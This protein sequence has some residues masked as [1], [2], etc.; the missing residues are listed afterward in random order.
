VVERGAVNTVQELLEGRAP[1]VVIQ[2]GSGNVGSGGRITVRGGTS[3]TLDN[4]PLLYVDGVR[5]SNAQATGPLSQ[6]FSPGPISRMNDFDPD[7]IERVEIIKGP[8]AATLYGTEASTGVINVITKKGAVGPAR[9]TVATRIGSAWLRDPEGRFPI[10]YGRD[11]AKNVVGL[12][13]VERENARGTPIF[14]R[15]TSQAYHLG[16]SAGTERL[17]YHLG[18]GYEASDGIERANQLRKHSARLNVTLVPTDRLSVEA[19]LGHVGGPTRLSPEG[20]HGSRMRAT[21]NSNPSNLPGMAPPGDTTRRG[22]GV[23]LPEEYDL[24]VT[25]GGAFEQDVDRLTASFHVEHRTLRWLSQRLRAGYDRTDATNTAFYPRVDALVAKSP[26]ANRRFG[27]KEITVTDGQYRTLD[28]AATASR[29]LRGGLR[30]STSIGGQYYRSGTNRM[31]SSGAD[32]PAEGLTAISSTTG[33]RVTEGDFAEDVT[34]GIYAEE[35]VAW[36]DRL[37]VTA[38]LR[39]DDNS[40]FGEN[41]DRIVYPKAAVS[42]VA[43]DERFVRV[44]WL[45]TLRLRAAY[46]EAGKQPSA[47][48]ALRTYQAVTGPGDGMAVTPLGIGNPNLR[49]ERGKE[50]EIGFDAAALGDRLSLDL[51]YYRKRTLDAIVPRELPPSGGVPGVQLLNVG[52]IRNSGIELL[53]R[54]TPWRSEGWTWDLSLNLATNENVVVSLG[55]PTLQ[56]LPAGEYRAHRTGHPAGSWFERRVLS[57]AMDSTGAVSNVMCDDGRGGATSCAGPDGSYGTADDAPSVY[58]GRTIPSVTDAGGPR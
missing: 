10:N 33:T 4:Q 21:V 58:L 47:F 22:F 15:G 24:F 53:A 29:S 34:L 55:D 18:G 17:R 52:E 27:Y 13:L 35:V 44:S 12:D 1:G 32:F 11:T 7:D 26:Y 57:A 51:T 37:F 23:S 43:S 6:F 46:G 45:N 48:D 38:A 54:A 42:W 49:A 41:F 3:L 40:A 30:S 25:R 50:L 31:L 8:A 14:S 9:W 16:V 28:Y 2:P 39:A 20:G 36:R 56:S 5:A 19:S